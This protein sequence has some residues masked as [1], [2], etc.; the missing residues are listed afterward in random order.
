MTPMQTNSGLD[1]AK[2]VASVVLE[3]AADNEQLRTLNEKTA[4]AL[5]HSGLMQWLNPTAAGG[6]EPG[7][8]EMI[9][10]W[11]ELARQDGS[12]GWIGI[13]NFPSAA[14]AAAYLPDAGFKEV[15][16]D[17][18]NHVTM[19]GQFFPNGTGDKV[20]GGYMVSGAWQFGTGHSESVCGGFI[21]MIDGE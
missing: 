1:M 6:S 8:R 7:Y 13:A 10:T 11:V 18:D 21:P 20:E 12:V 3:N 17:N 2:A 19:G 9:E 14:F 4:R 15:F 5:W 16:T